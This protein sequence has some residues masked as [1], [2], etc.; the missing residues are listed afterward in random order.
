MTFVAKGTAVVTRPMP[1]VVTTFSKDES[2]GNAGV[3]GMPLP[4]YETQ[5]CRMGETAAGKGS[6]AALRASEQEQKAGPGCCAVLAVR[7]KGWH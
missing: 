7:S 3:A 4:P 6:A 5:A 2:R 1:G